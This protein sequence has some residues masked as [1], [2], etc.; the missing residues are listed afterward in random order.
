MCGAAVFATGD[1]RQSFGSSKREG[2]NAVGAGREAG[3]RRCWP[4][5]TCPWLCVLVVLLEP[6]AQLG[7]GKGTGP[8]GCWYS[9][10][11]WGSL[12]SWPVPASGDT[13]PP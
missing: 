6:P 3:G 1:L 12:P 2:K 8:Y 9:V 7:E 10:V 5:R 13:P 11:G 4:S